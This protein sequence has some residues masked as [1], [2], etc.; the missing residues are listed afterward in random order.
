EAKIAVLTE[1]SRQNRENR[2]KLRTWE[3]TLAYRMAYR[4]PQ[5]GNVDRKSTRDPDSEIVRGREEAERVDRCRSGRVTFRRAVEP[6]R[7]AEELKDDGPIEFV[8]SPSR[9]KFSES[10]TVY[11][12]RIVALPDELLSFQANRYYTVE[13]DDQ[14]LKSVFAV[15]HSPRTRERYL[16]VWPLDTN[17]WTGEFIDPM[18]FFGHDRPTEDYLDRYLASLCGD[19]GPEDVAQVDRAVKITSRVVEG[20]T[21]LTLE[22][23][24]LGRVDRLEFR[25]RTGQLVAQRR[26]L[27]EPG[28]M[29]WIDFEL[30]W[31]YE[32]SGDLW[33]PKK[34]VYLQHSP[35][36]AGV[37]TRIDYEMLASKVN[38]PL[39]E[40]SFTESFLRA[41]G[42][43]WRATPDEKG[44]LVVRPEASTTP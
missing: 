13:G 24:L 39:P 31:E 5:S 28:K 6:D 12:E 19:L 27:K 43:A 23:D 38:S 1:L 26:W 20:E 34:I 16:P 44:I 7:L 29:P 17:P 10:R 2:Q 22:G 4:I 32:T 42:D 25:E 9:R 15:R 14:R 21:L 40:D 35:R 30:T 36:A 33:T 11:E 37:S 41:P 18:S 3:G 8:R